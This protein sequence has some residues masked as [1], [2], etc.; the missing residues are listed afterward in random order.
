MESEVVHFQKPYG[1]SLARGRLHYALRQFEPRE[2]ALLA[3][4]P[5]R[6]FG[7][8]DPAHFGGHKQLGAVQAVSDGRLEGQDQSRM[9]GCCLKEEATQRLQL[10]V[11]RLQDLGS[12]AKKV[13]FKTYLRVL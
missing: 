5:I 3:F 7:D 1:H 10:Q 6:L 9:H 11:M 8:R 4:P 2:S 12:V 13:R